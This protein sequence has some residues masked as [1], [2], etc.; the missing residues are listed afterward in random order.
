MKLTIVVA[1]MALFAL[2]V[3]VVGS[4]DQVGAA[5][6]VPLAQVS[7][8]ASQDV[9]TTPTQALIDTVD[10]ASG[11]ALVNDAL[12]VPEDGCYLAIFA[13]QVGKTAGGPRDFQAWMRIDGVDVPNSNVLVE[14]DNAT[15]DVIIS[16]GISCVAAGSMFTFWTQA[17]GNG[18]LME[19]IDLSPNPLV[20]AHIS[21]LYKVD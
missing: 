1:L 20:P 7:L 5:G 17:S 21:T 4:V 15:K 14:L 16:Q 12:V 3:G 8:S 6:H 2:T 19:A 10:T 13:P 18:V 11:I 9:G